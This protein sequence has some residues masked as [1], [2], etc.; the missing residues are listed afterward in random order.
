MIATPRPL[1]DSF[2]DRDAQTLAKALLGRFGIDNDQALELFHQTVS[3]KSVGNLTDF[4]RHHM[5][6]PFEVGPR[7]Q[8]LIG[9]FDDLDRAH[10]AVL[11]AQRFL[12]TDKIFAGILMIGLIGLVID[13]GFRLVQAEQCWHTSLAPLMAEV[14]QQMGDGP[15]YLSFDI[16]SLDPIWA[17]GTGTPEVGGLTS[18]QALEIVRGCRGLNLVGCDLVEVSPAYDTSGNT[19]LLGANLLLPDAAA[20]ATAGSVTA[21][22]A[23]VADAPSA[24]PAMARRCRYARRAASRSAAWRARASAQPSRSS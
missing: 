12:Q 22:P 6:E 9:H 20:T 18:I 13:Q 17:P 1:P 3:M 4:V 19:A 11:K 5:L 14:R 7:I 10:Q 16:D 23:V 15:V 8:A 2:F 21:A 24:A